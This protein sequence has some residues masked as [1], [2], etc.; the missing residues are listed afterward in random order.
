MCN[1]MDIRIIIK[2]TLSS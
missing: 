2:D 1:S